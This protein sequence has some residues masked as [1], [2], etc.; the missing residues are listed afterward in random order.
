VTA[1]NGALERMLT[2]GTPFRLFYMIA[3]VSETKNI[4]TG[5]LLKSKTENK[6]IDMCHLSKSKIT[7]NNKA[8]CEK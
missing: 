8:A 7:N 5:Y 6:C 3:R 1:V 2:D 4:E